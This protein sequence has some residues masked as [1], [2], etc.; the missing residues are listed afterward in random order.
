MKQKAVMMF[1]AVGCL[2][3][4]QSLAAFE[5]GPTG[6]LNPDQDRPFMRVRTDP[7]DP[8]V[9]WALTAHIPYPNPDYGVHPANGIYRSTDAGV[10]WTQMNDTLLTADIP[11]FDIAIDPTNSDVVYL[12]TNTL[13]IVKSTDG[14]QSWLPA[15]QGI[16]YQGAQFPES[17]WGVVALAVRPDDPQVLYAGIMQTYGV[18]LEQG[19]GEHPGLYKSFDGGSTWVERNDG[20]PDRSDP[21]TL[22]DLVSHTGSVWTIAILQN[23]PNIVLLGMVDMEANA[24]LGGDQVARTSSRVFYSFDGGE[25]GWNEASDGF[26]LIEEDRLGPYVFARVAISFTSLATNTGTDFLFVATHTGATS[27]ATIYPQLDTDTVTRSLGVFRKNRLAPWEPVNT[28][29]PVANDDE[30]IDSINANHVVVSPVNPNIMLVGVIDADSGDPGSDASNVYL[31]LNGGTS[32]GGGWATG[33]SVSEHGYTEA[34]P[35]FVDINA[36][37]TRAYTVVRWDFDP[38]FFSS[39]G[40][41]DDGIY[42]LPPLPASLQELQACGE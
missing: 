8:D 26:P 14:G 41:E 2:V 39:N 4:V 21:F 25:T 12:G 28:G 7:T 33:L 42:R 1:V 27:V 34:S 35:F 9:V 11:V 24:N 38:D 40:T 16:S 3:T 31:S 5:W 29:L 20:L 15:N 32:W 6:L 17:R 22:F 37:Q 23:R 30:N 10:T 36:N 13:G 19:A 18:E